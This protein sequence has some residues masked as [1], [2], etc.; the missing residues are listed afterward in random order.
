MEI[1]H[2]FKAAQ[3]S[4]KTQALINNRANG[5]AT[6]NEGAMKAAKE[7]ESVF[8]TNMLENMYTGIE[9]EEPFGGGH[10]EKIY[11]S[12][13][14]AEYGKEISKNGGLGL[15]DHIYRELLATQEG[16]VK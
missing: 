16:V 4:A 2:Q 12:M 7:F 5:K 9:A 14:I 3:L 8:I 10:A 1:A 15:S 6:V 11:R 13:Q